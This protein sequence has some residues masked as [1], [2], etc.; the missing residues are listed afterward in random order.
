MVS[1]RFEDAFDSHGGGIVRRCICDRV[2]FSTYFHDR[3]F[4]DEGELE[5]LEEKAKQFPEK[6]IG[7]DH[8]IGTMTVNG[9]GDMVFGCSCNS[10]ERY[11]EFILKN[12]TKIR[13]YLNN[14]AKNL[15]DKADSVEVNA[16]KI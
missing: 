10:F 2:H 16:D 13:N 3:N 5:D 8:T 11:E 14:F 12:A 1:E 9:V 6:Y 15:R 7:H 4:Y